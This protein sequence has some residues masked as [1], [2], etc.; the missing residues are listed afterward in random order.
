MSKIIIGIHGLGNKPPKK[1]LEAWWKKA[2]CEGLQAIGHP[3]AYFNFEL[4]YWADIFHS[5]PL[6][7]EQRDEKNPLFLDEPYTRAKGGEIKAPGNLR[8]KVLDFLEKQLD[9]LLLRKDLSINF[10][11]ITDMILRHYFKDLTAYYHATCQFEDQDSRLAKEA[12]REKLAQ[13]IHKHRKKEIMLIAHSMGSIVAYDVLVENAGNF[14]VDTFMTMGS[15]LGLP[16]I[17]G[18]IAAER[19]VAKSGRQ[20]L[21]TPENVM[22]NW[23][24]FSDL[25]DKIAFNYNLADDYD[26]NTRHVQIIDFV[27]NNDYEVNGSKNPHKAFGYLRSPEVA[28]AIHEFLARGQS[29]A[30][31]WLVEKVSRLRSALMGENND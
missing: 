7:P 8:K 22:R 16:V 2:I 12:I 11:A 23:L 15:P 28:E 20:K 1:L 14:Q 26:Q 29:E 31:I 9:G 10:S 25:N 4:V 21:T 30:R 18:K 19:G 17:M 5:Q 6:D 13:V 3:N 27:V 24:N